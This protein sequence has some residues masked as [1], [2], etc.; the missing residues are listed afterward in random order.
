MAVTPEQ[1]IE[2]TLPPGV[3]A[4]CRRISDIREVD[5]DAATRV[6]R[7]VRLA[8]RGLPRAYR[9]LDCDVARTLRGVCGGD[10][11]RVEREG[12]SLEDTAAV[13]LGVARLSLPSQ[14][15]V[16]G[17]RSAR[18]LALLAAADASLDEP[19]AAALAAW[20]AA[21][22]AAELTAP[23]FSRL[24][25]LLAGSTPLATVDVARALTAAVAAAPLGDTAELVE[26]AA[27]LLLRHQGPAGTFPR[28]LGPT[29]FRRRGA[30]TDFATQAWAVQALA[31][32]ST[33]TGDASL[34]AAA[35][36][37][38]GLLISRQ[39]AGGQ[40]WDGY[41]VRDGSVVDERSVRSGH[42]ASLAPAALLDLL[43]AGGADHRPAVAAGLGWVEQHPE[44]VEEI[45]SERFGL[46][47]SGVD[48]G[49]DGRA[50]VEHSCRPAELG[51]LLHT[52]LPARDQR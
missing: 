16:L 26:R 9:P 20:A 52:W 45:V 39:G 40:W 7:L 46:V 17:G 50:V 49:R 31:R 48:R 5:L 47:W 41:D 28:L 8:T 13:A 19:G 51:W 15:Q 3:S 24:T 30:V 23:V 6:R 12:A 29:P 43:D 21:E 27:G 22:V 10:G 25:G 1:L 37:A 44:V 34:L 42:Q 11:V 32:A 14:R 33:L 18:D 38:A 35:N 2:G 4:S 36:R